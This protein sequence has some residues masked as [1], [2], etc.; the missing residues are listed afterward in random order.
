MYEYMK[1]KRRTK[2]ENE[3][4]T[5]KEPE[6]ENPVIPEPS[7]QKIKPKISIPINDDGSFDFTSMREA[8]KERL[9]AA[10]ASSPSLFPSGPA[11][12]MA[13]PPAV[14]YA[15]YGGVGAIEAMLAQRFGKI[16]KQIAD[17]VFAYTPQELELLYPPT[18]KVLQ[19]YAAEWMIKYQDEIALATLLTSMTVAKVNAAVTL[20]RTHKAEVV[21][22]PKPKEDKPE[23]VQ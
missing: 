5:I 12:V 7:Q 22:M 13:F 3:I 2:V 20:A 1:T 14:I 8:T 9:R 19:K 17:Q 10:V 18:A 15:M 16:P 11:E 4:F 21:E 6:V 23:V